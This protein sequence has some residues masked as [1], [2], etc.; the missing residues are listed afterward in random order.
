MRRLKRLWQQSTLNKV[1]IIALIAVPVVIIGG[2][3]GSRLFSWTGVADYTKPPGIDERGKTLWD[4]LELLIIPAVLAGGALWFSQAERETE[5]KIADERI[6]E[7]ALQGYLDKITEL[8]L[9]PL[10][11]SL[12]SERIRAVARARTLTTLRQLD[13]SRKATL[14]QFL[15]EAKLI[16]KKSAIIELR[17][18]DLSDIVLTNLALDNADLTEATL[19]RA[20]LVFLSL[21]WADLSGV[22]LSEASLAK[23][24]LYAADLRY[25]NLV[26]TTLIDVDLRKAN[27]HGAKFAGRDPKAITFADAASRGLVATKLAKV[28]LDEA[29]YDSHTRWP[30][31]FTPPPSAIKED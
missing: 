7:A 9:D 24:S 4:W 17:G 13:G 29:R 26:G 30:E 28:N 31:G 19:R 10:P 1:I 15:H 8:L 22:D 14:L 18:A 21:R 12:D 27:L 6:R 3:S 5:R 2:Y 23:V 11:D 16:D 20:T 25:A